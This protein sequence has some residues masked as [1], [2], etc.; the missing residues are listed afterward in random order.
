[1]GPTVRR[2]KTARQRRDAHACNGSHALRRGA[3]EP[4]ARSRP[5]A[6]AAS[7]I[8]Y[9]LSAIGYR[10][11]AVGYLFACSFCAATKLS[12]CSVSAFAVRFVESTLSRKLIRMASQS[13]FSTTSDLS[14]K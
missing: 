11:S 5:R 12:P 4:R 7:A 3:D 6:R 2:R 10:L 8:G 13:P 1:M 9:W 14:R